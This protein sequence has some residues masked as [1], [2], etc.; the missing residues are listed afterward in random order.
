MTTPRTRIL[1]VEDEALI[2]MQMAMQLSSSGFE[3]CG[4]VANAEAAIAAARRE[5]PDLVLL[6]IG[7]PGEMDGIGAAKGILA[8]SRPKIV[9]TTGQADPEITARAM[10]ISPLAYLTKP[11][12]MHSLMAIIAGAGD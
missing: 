6:D 3:V 7:L 2:A 11:V 5:S 9:F 4:R 1:I 8:F 12:D 10:A